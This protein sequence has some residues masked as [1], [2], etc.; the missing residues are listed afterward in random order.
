MLVKSNGAW[1]V[2]I[3]LVSIVISFGVFHV[4]FAPN[5]SRI[6][7]HI[8]TSLIFG[9]LLIV[10]TPS[11]S[12]VAGN[13]AIAAFFAPFISTSPFKGVGPVITNFSNW[14]PPS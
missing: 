7:Q 6:V 10:Q 12:N 11:I 1:V 14:I 4:I 5:F 3:F 9:K 2:I 8:W 13:I